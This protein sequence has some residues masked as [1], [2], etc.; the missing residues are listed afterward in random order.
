MQCCACIGTRPR[1]IS[2]PQHWS[3]LTTDHAGQE[4][5]DLRVRVP[6]GT[7]VEPTALVDAVMNA[8]TIHIHSLQNA[9]PSIT[10]T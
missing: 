9:K 5:V 1:C 6:T 8:T 3:S 7:V 10:A 2:C 4:S